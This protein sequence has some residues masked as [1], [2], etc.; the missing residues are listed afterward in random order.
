MSDKKIATIVSEVSEG[1]QAM[2]KN[3]PAMEHDRKGYQPVGERPSNPQPPNLGSAAV[4]PAN[5]NAQPGNGSGSTQGTSSKT[6]D[7]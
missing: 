7:Q 2:S 5:G 3:M 1:Y 6:A 4:V